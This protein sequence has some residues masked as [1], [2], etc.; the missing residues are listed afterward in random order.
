MIDKVCNCISKK[1]EPTIG[2]QTA[3]ELQAGQTNSE[4]AA[5]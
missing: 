2:G 5:V 4:K 1:H 3:L